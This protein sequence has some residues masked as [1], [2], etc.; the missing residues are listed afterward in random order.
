EVRCQSRGWIGGAGK[1]R[2]RGIVGAIPRRSNAASVAETPPNLVTD[3]GFG[4]LGEGSLGAAGPRAGP[5]ARR[6]HGLGIA[7]HHDGEER[8]RRRLPLP[9]D[10]QGLLIDHV[11]ELEGRRAEPARYR[12]DRTLEAR[13]PRRP[14][15]EM[16]DGGEEA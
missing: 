6:R 5:P 11:R 8:A 12:V 7:R 14:A 1:A 10:V 15:A 9:L 3:F 16:V 4:T 2:Q 13:E